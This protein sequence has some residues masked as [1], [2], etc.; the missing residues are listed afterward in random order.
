SAQARATSRC[1]WRR[2]FEARR[3]SR[4]TWRQSQEGRPTE[5]RALQGALGAPHVR[6]SQGLPART[7]PKSAATLGGPMR[8]IGTLWA[9]RLRARKDHRSLLAL[10]SWHVPK[11]R[12]G[13]AARSSHAACPVTRRAHVLAEQATSS[14]AK[15]C[16][17]KT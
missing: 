9:M 7:L 2:A 14:P 12:R 4:S 13:I 8:D 1:P 6:R 16:G 15:A 10:L 17:A 11:S 5:C 3:R